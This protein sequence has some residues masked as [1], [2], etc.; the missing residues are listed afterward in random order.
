MSDLSLK[1][2]PSIVYALFRAIDDVNELLPPESQLTKSLHTT[3]LGPE[4]VLD[5]MGFVNLIAAVEERIEET[6]G[7][8]VCL[9]DNAD[10]ETF[11][12]IGALASYICRRC[13]PSDREGDA[14]SL[15]R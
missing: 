13:P 12:T 7:T 11:R 1:A 14:H 6:L 4:A 15:S 8:A 3:L 2:D 5:S 9:A 10:V